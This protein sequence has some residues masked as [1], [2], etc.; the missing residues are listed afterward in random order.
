MVYFSIVQKQTHGYQI[1]LQMS[2]T[3]K[4]HLQSLGL[5]AIGKLF[6][7]ARLLLGD[8]DRSAIEHSS[9]T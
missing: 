9:L 5:H 7:I 1:Y 3:D 2:L 8:G 6:F 4:P